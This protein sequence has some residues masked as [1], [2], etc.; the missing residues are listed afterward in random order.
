VG[1]G[2]PLKELLKAEAVDDDLLDASSFPSLPLAIADT[3]SGSL[4]LRETGTVFPIALRLLL[5][6]LRE[7]F[8][9]RLAEL[10]VPASLVRAT[11]KTK[12]L[13]ILHGHGPESPRAQ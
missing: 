3:D 6:E 7:A 12:S 10:R 4:L 1:D 8:G 11:T 2:C 9:I 13:R 5:P